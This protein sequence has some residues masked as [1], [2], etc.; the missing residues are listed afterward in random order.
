[1]PIRFNT[2]NMPAVVAEGDEIRIA[3]NQVGDGFT[4]SLYRDGEFMLSQSF[5]APVG[6]GRAIV[7]TGIKVSV[8]IKAV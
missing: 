8:P 7:I 1:M 3:P 6:L 5:G 2:A 4:F